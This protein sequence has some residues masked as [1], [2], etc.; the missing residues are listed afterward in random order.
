[1]ETP[2]AV[3]DALDAGGAE[4]EGFD[5]SVQYLPLQPL[6]QLQTTVSKFG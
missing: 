4:F 2:A 3:A 6:S 1:M 5:P